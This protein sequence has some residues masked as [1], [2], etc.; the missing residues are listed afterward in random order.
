MLTCFDVAEYFLAHC[1]EESGDLISNLKLQKL[2]YYAQ[3]FSLALLGRPL[4]NEKIEAWMHGP[5]VPD[6]Y[7]HYKEHGNGALPVPD[8]F[9]TEKFSEDEMGLLDEVYKVYGQFSAWKLR[10]M[11]HEEAPWVK[12][13]IEG[14]ASQEIK[15]EIMSEFF[16]TL[17]N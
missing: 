16:K 15:P 12:T 13:Y 9:N 8:N 5:V 7:H 11:S 1:D 10:N 2:S 3:G 14:A 4:F 17:I 6:L